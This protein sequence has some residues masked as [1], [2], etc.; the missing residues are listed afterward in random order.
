MPKIFNGLGIK[1]KVMLLALLPVAFASFISVYHAIHKQNILA[2]NALNER[3]ELLAKYLSSSS[4]FAIFSQNIEFLDSLVIMAFSEKEVREIAIWGQKDELLLQRSQYQDNTNNDGNDNFTLIEFTEFI[5]QTD[6]EISDFE[7]QRETTY[8]PQKIGRITVKLS[9][10]RLQAQQSAIIWDSL[11]IS[12][13][14]LLL[15]SCLGWLLGKNITNP[16]VKLTQAVKNIQLGKLSVRVDTSSSHEI[17]TLE[18]GFNMMAS[19]VENS[20]EKLRNEVD[21]ATS[22]LRAA[23]TELKHKNKALTKARKT[24]L[25]LAEAKSDFLATMSHEIRT[26]VSGVLGFTQLLGFSALSE[27]QRDYVDSISSATGQLL[28]VIDDILIFSK[29]S[30]EN[31]ELEAIE[32]NLREVIEQNIYN[33]SPCAYEKKIEVVTLFDK[34]IPKLVMGDIDK[35]SRILN[36]ILNNAIKFTHFGTVTISVSRLSH[37]E[38]IIKISDTGIGIPQ[39][40]IDSIF[41]PFK[42]SETSISRRFGG[43]GLG[44]SIVKKLTKSMGGKIKVESHIN[45]GS[46][47]TLSLSLKETNADTTNDTLLTKNKVL[48]FEP[49]PMMRQSLRNDILNLGSHVIIDRKYQGDSNDIISFLGHHKDAD[50]VV[51]GIMNYGSLSDTISEKISAVRKVFQGSLIILSHMDLNPHENSENALINIQLLPRPYRLNKLLSILHINNNKETGLADNTGN[52]PPNP[53]SGKTVLLAE[54]TPFNRK[55]ICEFLKRLGVNVVAVENG[56]KAL[57]YANKR[58]YDAILLDIHM[59]IFG[60]QEVARKIRSNGLNA[61]TP[62]LAITA[63]VF[64]EKNHPEEKNTFHQVLIKPI[65][66]SSLYKALIGCFNNT[67]SVTASLQEHDESVIVNVPKHLESELIDNLST[68]SLQLSNAVKQG[69]VKTIHEYTHKL[70]GLSGYFHIAGLNHCVRELNTAIKEQPT[71]DID[72]VLTFVIKEIEKVINEIKPR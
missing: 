6:I 11:F 25:E 32:F 47:F 64:F 71:K 56:E 10:N 22:E 28:N 44:L 45:K 31:V 62:I 9:Q 18:N 60:G 69:D 57:E 20:H 68:Y 46:E 59:P 41:E 36:N 38:L 27:S 53:I 23:I 14:I 19:Y 54:D 66:E 37:D 39:D 58:Q 52:H 16:I 61:T 24:A 26:P 13:F 72:T 65:T 5:Y 8:S 33:H 7:E 3:G 51:L 34:N 40:R 50:A 63:D 1:G 29:L 30:T 21:T 4:E 17:H 42:Q 2:S 49:H 48:V 12:L 67:H 55:I 35:F 43:T 70:L 15:C